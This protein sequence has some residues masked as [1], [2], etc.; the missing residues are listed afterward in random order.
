MSS[1]TDQAGAGR[2]P[3]ESAI[4]GVTV[5]AAV[6]PSVLYGVPCSPEIA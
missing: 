2:P 6:K 5:S 3:P 4:N 1:A